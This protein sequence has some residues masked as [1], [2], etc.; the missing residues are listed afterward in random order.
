MRRLAVLA[1]GAA[2]ALASPAVADTRAAARHYEAAYL[3]LSAIDL[4][5]TV[6]CLE[7]HQCEEGNPLFGRHPSTPRLI[8][9]KLAL[10][11][12]HFTVFTRLN[13]RN[14]SAALRMAQ[15]SCVAQGGVVALNLRFVF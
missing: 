6:H 10:G 11:A 14:P 5:E 13:E 4:A 7:R 9:S 15:I 2:L 12:L 8:A 1:A 3:A